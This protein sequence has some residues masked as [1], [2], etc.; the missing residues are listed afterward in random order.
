[1]GSAGNPCLS[2]A[3]FGFPEEPIPRFAARPE[4]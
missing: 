1:M 4:A 3:S 2:K